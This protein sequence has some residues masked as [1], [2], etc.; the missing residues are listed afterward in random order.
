MRVAA[1]DVTRMRSE[2]GVSGAG[3]RRDECPCERARKRAQRLALDLDHELHAG[4]R[5]VTRVPRPRTR[6]DA[7]AQGNVFY[8]Y[9]APAVVVRA[10]GR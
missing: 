1:M 9:E 2:G 8:V 6:R 4:R 10:T 7:A 5:T 3:T